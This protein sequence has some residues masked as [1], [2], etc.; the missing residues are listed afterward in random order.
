MQGED[1]TLTFQ[2]PNMHMQC[3]QNVQGNYEDWCIGGK[4]AD[5]DYVLGIN[6]HK[7]IRKD[8]GIRK[9]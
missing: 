2:V 7:H 9:K 4:F 5:W 1:W 3:L 6:E 8:T